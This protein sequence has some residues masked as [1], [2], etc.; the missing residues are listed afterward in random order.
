MTDDDAAR[1]ELVHQAVARGLALRRTLILFY[2]LLA[3]AMLVLAGACV[4]SHL[5]VERSSIMISVGI[6]FAFLGI[7]AAATAIVKS[8]SMKKRP[9]IDVNTREPLNRRWPETARAGAILA[10]TIIAAAGV[11]AV[12]LALDSVVMAVGV[13]IAGLLVAAI[14]PLSARQFE[15]SPELLADMLESDPGQAEHYD[16]VHPMWLSGAMAAGRGRGPRA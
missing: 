8:A 3:G 5:V 12:I 11:L 14:G 7:A 9:W 15:T 13:A 16:T 1:R 6:A 2:L 4:A 10:F